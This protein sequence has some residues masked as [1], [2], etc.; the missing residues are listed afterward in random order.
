MPDSLYIPAYSGH[1]GRQG[2]LANALE[3]ALFYATSFRSTHLDRTQEIANVSTPVVT[4][5]TVR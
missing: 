2:L 1:E 5:F 4:R 3:I